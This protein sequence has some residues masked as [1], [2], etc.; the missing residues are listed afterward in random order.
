MDC[1]RRLTGENHVYAVGLGEGPALALSPQLCFVP[2]LPGAPLLTT[3]TESFWHRALG[4]QEDLASSPGPSTAQLLEGTQP[5]RAE[6]LSHCAV[7]SH[8][9][10]WALRRKKE[11]RSQDQKAKPALVL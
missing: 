8:N 2:S 11:K 1:Q 4:S 7:L 10:H 5:T 3:R 6:Y 9:S